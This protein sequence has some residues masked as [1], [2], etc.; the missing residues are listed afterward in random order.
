VIPPALLSVMPK[1]KL[2]HKNPIQYA[3][4]KKNMMV[5]NQRAHTIR[6]KT[7]VVINLKINT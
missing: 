7:I 6:A 1:S 4:K 2:S 5:K 3:M